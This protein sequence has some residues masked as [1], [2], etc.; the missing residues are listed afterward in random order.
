MQGAIALPQEKLFYNT[1]GGLHYRTG[2]LYC[3]AQFHLLFPSHRYSVSLLED[4]A[5]CSGPVL[6]RSLGDVSEGSL[7]E[8]YR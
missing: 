6:G 8:S 3:R 1:S 5:R 7:R 4:V 2:F